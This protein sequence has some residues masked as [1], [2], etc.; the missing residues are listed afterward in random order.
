MTVPLAIL[1]VLA[2]AAGVWGNPWLHEAQLGAFLGP[3]L[4]HGAEHRGAAVYVLM[5]VSLLAALA[6]ITVA[7]R[8]YLMGGVDLAKVGVPQSTL[9]RILLHKYYVD[10]LYDRVFVRP[11]VALAGWCARV[12]DLGVIDGAVNGMATLVLRGASALRR[13]QTGFV[14][15]YALSMLVGVVALLGILLWRK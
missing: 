3:V 10:E 6:G 5:G 8:M 14:M 1:A 4:G 11:T 2:A 9:H 12:F 13:Y 15:N 7:V